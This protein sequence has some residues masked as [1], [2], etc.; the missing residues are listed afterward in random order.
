MCGHAPQNGPRTGQLEYGPGFRRKLSV[1]SK[2]CLRFDAEDVEVGL[3][4]E[5]LKRLVIG[6]VIEPTGILCQDEEFVGISD[7]G[8]IGNIRRV[9]VR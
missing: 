7:G 9:Q 1:G 3:P 6:F 2:I 4:R 8:G 5:L